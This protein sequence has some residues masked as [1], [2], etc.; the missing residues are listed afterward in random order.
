MKVAIHQPNFLPWWPFFEKMAKAD[1]FVVLRHCQFEKNNFQN[2]FQYR[3][4]WLT[5]STYSGLDPI[6]DKKYVSPEK[7][8]K[9]IKDKLKDKKEILEKFD[10]LVSG[11][12]WE[13]NYKIINSAAELLGIK[14]KIILDEPTELK[15]TERLVDICKKLGATK[16]ISGS[17]AKKYLDCSAFES[18]S[19]DVEFQDLKDEDRVHILDKL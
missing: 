4:N 7:D 6:F 1:V 11:S 9:R 10:G 15:S 3:G 13:T 17:G 18:A 8:W 14:T 12:L 19:I 16:Y 5:M 2:R